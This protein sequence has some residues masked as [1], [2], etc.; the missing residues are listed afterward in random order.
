MIRVTL[1]RAGEKILGF[2]CKGHAG[3]APEGSD[4]ICAAVSVLTF[5][6]ANAL[7]SVAGKKAEAEV[8]DGYMR[9]CLPEAEASRETQIIFRTIAQGFGDLAE[10]YPKYLR[11]TEN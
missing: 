6:C 7:E 10:E 4:I 5:T 9:V 11:L 3:Y 8:K 1:I 2:E